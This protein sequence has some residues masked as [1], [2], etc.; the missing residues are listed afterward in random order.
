M[1]TIFD[2]FVF[3]FLENQKHFVGLYIH[4]SNLK[5]HAFLCNFL[6]Q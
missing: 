5:L 3:I 2:I 4:N 1:W 6:S